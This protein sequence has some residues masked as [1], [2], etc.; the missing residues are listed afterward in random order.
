MR[1]LLQVEKWFIDR[2]LAELEDPHGE[3][4]LDLDVLDY[5]AYDDRRPTFCYGFY[6]Q[7]QYLV[8]TPTC[9]EIE[10]V[11]VPTIFLRHG[12]PYAAHGRR[13]V[14]RRRRRAREVSGAAY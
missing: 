10:Q 4:M 14:P 7:R 2:L 8:W 1:K 5:P 3:L 12:A 9:A 11:L 13:S 6:D